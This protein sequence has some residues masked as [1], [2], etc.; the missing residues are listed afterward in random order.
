VTVGD[1]HAATDRFQKSL[2]EA[3]LRKASG[4]QGRAAAR[5]GLS[6]HP[7]RHQMKK[8]GMLAGA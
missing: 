3:A 7:L 8:L 4:R 6:R 5:L 2:I 1:F